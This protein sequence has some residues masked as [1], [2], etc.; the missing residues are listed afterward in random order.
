MY[1]VRNLGIISFEL[2]N[3]EVWINENL[4]KTGLTTMDSFEYSENTCE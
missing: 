2:V 4:S 1:R 3:G